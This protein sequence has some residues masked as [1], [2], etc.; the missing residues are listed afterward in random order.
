MTDDVIKNRLCN[1]VGGSKPLSFDDALADVKRN[2]RLIFR[3]RMHAFAILM[4]QTSYMELCERRGWTFVEKA[5]KA[6]ASI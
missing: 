2:V 6:A 5:P 1:L 3:S 4:L